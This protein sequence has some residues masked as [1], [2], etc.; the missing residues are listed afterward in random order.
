MPSLSPLSSLG[1]DKFLNRETLARTH[2]SFT[3]DPRNL[4][5]FRTVNITAVCNRICTVACKRVARVK[6]ST[7]QKFVRTRVSSGSTHKEFWSFIEVNSYIC[8]CGLSLLFHFVLLLYLSYSAKSQGL[9]RS[10]DWIGVSRDRARAFEECHISDAIVRGIATE[11]S[12]ESCSNVSDV[13]PHD[14]RVSV[15]KSLFLV[16]EAKAFEDIELHND[17]RASRG[18]SNSDFVPIATSIEDRSW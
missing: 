1:P 8:I 16:W 15:C 13:I 5:S 9:Q 12:R 10:W 18:G 4:A 6:N 17:W 2:L 11:G 14:E 7:V 3:R